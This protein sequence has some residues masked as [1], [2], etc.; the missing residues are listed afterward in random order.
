VSHDERAVSEDPRDS[1]LTPNMFLACLS[2]TID[3]LKSRPNE[4][5]FWPAVDGAFR[6]RS[7]DRL[8][9]ELQPVIPQNVTIKSLPAMEPSEDAPDSC[10][11]AIM[12]KGTENSEVKMFACRDC[13]LIQFIEEYLKICED[14]MNTGFTRSATVPCITQTLECPGTSTTFSSIQTFS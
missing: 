9:K 6:I 11:K 13:G 2:Q 7:V 12:L 4:V 5:V 14:G 10:T 1:P 3:A 8:L